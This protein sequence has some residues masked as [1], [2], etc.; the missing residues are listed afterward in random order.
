MEKGNK[1]AAEDLFGRLDAGESVE[2]EE[3]DTLFE[4]TTKE[5]KGNE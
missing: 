1:K 4:N 2:I 5:H 3:V